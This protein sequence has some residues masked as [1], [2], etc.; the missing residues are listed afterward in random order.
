METPESIMTEEQ[1]I[2]LIH[3]SLT[4]QL[5]AGEL[6]HLQEWLAA[7]AQNQEIYAEIVEGWE[8]AKHFELPIEVNIDRAFDKFRATTQEPVPT[9]I[10]TKSPT[11]VRRLW[12]AIS[13]VAAI[14]L[15]LIGVIW[16]WQST[17]S[18]N[19]MM[20]ETIAT[21]PRTLV[22]LPDQSVVTLNKGAKIS[23]DENFDKRQIQL[24]GE[25]FFEVTKNP[26]KPFTILTKNTATTVLG[27]SFNINNEATKTTVT[28]FTGKVSF[29]DRAGKNGSLILTPTDR[30]IY[31]L[32]NQ[33]LS[34]EEKIAL[35]NINWQ[36]ENITYQDQ[37]LSEILP[38]LEAFYN[39]SIKLN[40]PTLSNCTFTGSFN[41]ASL[42]NALE[43]LSFGMNLTFT[44]EENQIL[45]TGEGCP[46]ASR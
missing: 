42:S 2:P 43:S 24:D 28:V 34:K 5:S 26:K 39:I 29:A 16:A 11:P 8:L 37:A 21:T 33:S 27:T 18:S 4:D 35:E 15:L 13:A 1:Y 45:L 31:Q 9:T 3:R 30:G 44:Q 17:Q 19:S 20:V 46:A 36:K 12:P 10:T 38:A 7:S 32:D 14:G 22:T 25:A 23:Y 40:E 41:R 6:V